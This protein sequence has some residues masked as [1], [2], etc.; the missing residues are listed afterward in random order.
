MH[1][2]YLNQARKHLAFQHGSVLGCRLKAIIAILLMCFCL[3]VAAFAQITIVSNTTVNAGDMSLEN[4][5]VIVRGATLTVNGPHTFNSLRITS[6]GAVTHSPKGDPNFV[7][8]LELT[9]IGDMTVDLGSKVD[10]TGRGFGPG[11]G[12]GRGYNNP[13]DGGGG[14]AY[15]GEGTV[16]NGTSGSIYGDIRTLIDQGNGEN[17]G[18]G[19]GYGYAG[20]NP[21][22]SGGGAVR[23]T[24]GG[25]LTLNGIFLANGMNSPAHGGAG[26]GG[27]IFV[28]TQVLTGGGIMNANGGYGNNRGGGGGGG[29]IAVHFGSNTAFFGTI[30]ALG[31]RS[32]DW[33]TRA[34]AGT[35]FVKQLGEEE[36]DLW[37]DNAGNGG[38][39]TVLVKEETFRN[40]LIHSQGSLNPPYGQVLRLN[41]LNDLTIYATGRISADGRGHRSSSGPGRG[42]DNASDGG[43]GAAYGGE[44]TV[45]QGG[46][47]Q[48]NG[49]LRDPNETEDGTHLGSGGG[50]GYGGNNPGSSGGGALRITVGGTLTVDGNISANGDRSPAH[51]GAGS[52]GSIYLRVKRLKGIGIVRA[53]GGYGNNRGGGGGG[54]RIAIYYDSRDTDVKLQAFGDRSNDWGTFAGAGTIFLQQNQQTNGDLHINNNGNGGLRT[55]FFSP[56]TFDNVYV[57][58]QGVLSPAYLT[59]LDFT[60]IGNFTVSEA[61]VSAGGLGYGAGAGPGKGYNGAGDGGQGGGYGGR[62][63]DLNG[64]LGPATYGSKELPTDFGSG[65]GWGYGNPNSY[66]GGVGGGALYIKVNGTLENNGTIDANGS[67]GGAHGGGGSGGSVLLRVGQ[68]SGNGYIRAIGGYGNNRGGG[69]GG[70]RIALYYTTKAAYT[71]T[72]EAAGNRCNDTGRFAENGT[73]Y[74][75]Q[76]GSSLVPTLTLST[77]VLA[78]GL[79]VAGT[80]A[81]SGPAPEGGLSVALQ[82]SDP[83]AITA[84][85][86]VLIPEGETSVTFTISANSVSADRMVTLGAR[87]WDGLSKV[88]ITVKPWL[89]SLT[90]SPS[91]V[92]GGQNTTGLLRLNV[93]APAGGLTVSLN[94]SDPAVVVPATVTVPGGATG[95]TFDISTTAVTATKRV[96]IT[97]TY[98][99]ESRTG[100]II[101]NPGNLTVQSLTFAPASVLGGQRATGI[102]SLSGKAPTGGVTIALH[103]GDSATVPVP[104]TVTIP[105]GR[106]SASFASV[107][108][109]VTTDKA[110]PVTAA[111]GS[112]NVVR[113]LTVG[114]PKI[115]SL[116]LVPSTVFGGETAIGVVTLNSPTPVPVTVTISSDDNAAFPEMTLIIP[117]GQ[118]VGAFFIDT[119]TV[120][121]TTTA[122][123]TVAANGSA[124][125]KMLTITP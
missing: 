8:G 4:Q 56:E 43:G 119:N 27:S 77:Q 30:Q 45:Y 65:G 52:G 94:S 5:D 1:H 71:G 96:V 22:S 49:N 103:S 118:Q 2:R 13:F 14:A 115:A 82:N 57:T 99:G 36:G 74:Q 15:G 109:K 32:N 111:L 92:N 42:Y 106:S 121:A 66:R 59:Q 10:V 60:V 120:T 110:V 50:Y 63:A 89:T 69:G 51:G 78:G 34:G 38:W 72:L 26:S 40:V 46:S 91:S 24:V 28:T 117:A 17:L 113:V 85:P 112:S 101:V 93:P 104:A 48:P 86:S 41:V 61:F 33:G 124:K 81:I 98:L 11:Q 7:N 29:R 97:L 55:Y 23:L 19:G 44:G 123:I 31:N 25:T 108:A 83:A 68:L 9:V 3:Q 12:P 62:G 116:E 18:S 70:G 35:V 79:S 75:E 67:S 90:M 114:V 21:G 88:D 73:I 122:T 20:S 16:Y 6:N 64:N 76:A 107:T 125:S 100:Q 84:P 102:I 53:N 39:G 87:L 47:G 37:I 95:R 105:A 80:V 54:G 58:G